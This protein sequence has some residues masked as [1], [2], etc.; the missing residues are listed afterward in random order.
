MGGVLMD[1]RRCRELEKEKNELSPGS[2]FFF[3]IVNRDIFGELRSSIFGTVEDVVLANEYLRS[4]LAVSNTGVVN[5]PLPSPPASPPPPRPKENSV[6]S[7]VVGVESRS[8]D[9]YKE[10]KQK[11]HVLKCFIF[12]VA[13]LRRG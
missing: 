13:V 5:P 11:L 7:G 9:Y 8:V 6:L 10:R 12:P 3:L 4:L 2:F 1:Q